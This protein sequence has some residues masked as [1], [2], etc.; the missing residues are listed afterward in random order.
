MQSSGGVVG[1]G[2]R[3]VASVVPSRPVAAQSELRQNL[4][5]PAPHLTAPLIR[6]VVVAKDV[7]DGMD[8]QECQL[9]LARMASLVRLRLDAEK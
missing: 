7:Q 6:V 3:S 2:K 9:A 4:F 5:L 1:V 8:G